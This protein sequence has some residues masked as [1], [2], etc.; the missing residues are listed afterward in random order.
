MATMLSGAAI[1]DAA[2]LVI[3]ANEECP[4]PQTK[5]HL[6]ALDIIGIKNIIIVQNKIDL[7]DEE[8]ILENYNQI[9]EFV[10]GTIAE[11]APIIPISAQHNANID[12]LIEEIE[13]KFKTPKR[14]LK[15]N[16]LFFVARSFDVNKP[17]SEIDKLVGGILG[18]AIKQGKLKVGD[19]IEIKPGLKTEKENKQIWVPVETE[20]GGLHCG[21]ISVKE[22]TPGGSSAIMTKLDPSI[23]KTDQLAGNVVG[24]HGKMPGVWYEFELK[25]KLLDRVVGAKDDLVVEPIKKAEV[26]MLNVNSTATVGV[27]TDLHKDTIHIKLKIPVCADKK[28][29][30]TISRQLGN[31]WRLIGFGE[32]QK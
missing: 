7:V 6:M 20:I 10:K 3:A 5:E 29:R 28:D 13:K 2:I 25:Q 22:I 16:P 31:R 12:V 9:K 14:D 19:K 8:G 24:L 26:L 11:K 4:Q 30:I 23:V 18:G 15:K 1:M 17:G 32:I 27:V 21:G